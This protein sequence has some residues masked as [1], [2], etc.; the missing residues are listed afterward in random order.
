[1]NIKRWISLLLAFVMV[2]GCLPHTVL[3][4]SADEIETTETITQAQLKTL[5][6]AY[7]AK[8]T[9]GNARYD[10][11]ITNYMLHGTSGDAS[12]DA[13]IEDI[14]IFDLEEENL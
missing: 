2:V 5:L 11:L 7:L 1:M 9:T 14:F 13:A 4:V 6:E 12:F 8:G 3:T 10:R